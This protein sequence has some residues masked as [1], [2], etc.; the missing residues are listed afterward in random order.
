M[1]KL[2]GYGDIKLFAGSGSQ[3]LAKEISEY[4]SVPLSS[5]DLLEFQNENLF[6]RLHGSVRG[7]DVYLIQSMG[8]PVH[9]N[10]MENADHHRLSQT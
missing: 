6:V 7:Q 5:Y 4:L 10:L 9:R 8:P 3:E 1:G 2:Y